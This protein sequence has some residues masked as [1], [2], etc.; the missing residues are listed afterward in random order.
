[1]TRAERIVNSEHRWG[2][3]QNKPHSPQPESVGSCA[4]L[5]RI[6]SGAEKS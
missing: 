3:F 1:M 5:C 2:V 4:E 6:H